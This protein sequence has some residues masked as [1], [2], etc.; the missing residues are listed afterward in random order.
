[1]TTPPWRELAHRARAALD[2]I[3]ACAAT[4]VLTGMGT[5]APRR[6]DVE[7]AEPNLW[8]I[9]GEEGLLALHDG[10]AVHAPVGEQWER[11]L[12]GGC[13]LPSHL[14]T[15]GWGEPQLFEQPRAFR[16][17]AFFDEPHEVAGRPVWSVLLSAPGRKPHD[18]T[19]SLDRETALV[20]R[21]A[22]VDGLHGAEVEALDLSWRARP[23]VFTWTGPAPTAVGEES[24]RAREERIDR[25]PD[26]APPE[27]G[28]TGAP[29]PGTGSR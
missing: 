27:F 7:F 9:T 18:M 16:E 24:R 17:A 3:G 22:S 12:T 25:C 13:W 15:L 2:G 26:P 19:V 14:L 8:R 21:W 29:R 4:V 11:V 6:V 20:L 1:M 10:E 28:A 5:A 23:D